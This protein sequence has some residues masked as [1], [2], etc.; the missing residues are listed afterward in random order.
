MTFSVETFIN[1]KDLINPNSV[2]ELLHINY[3]QLLIDTA[4][5]L[6]NKNTELFLSSKKNVNAYIL[7]LV[8]AYTTLTAD[9]M[10]L[11]NNLINIKEQLNTF[12]INNVALKE[13]LEHMYE[14]SEGS[15]ELINDY[16]QLYNINYTKN[17]GIL[18]SIIFSCYVMSTIFKS[19]PITL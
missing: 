4:N 13:E 11:S 19:K 9:S 14:M 7:N 16:K 1:P 18:L 10:R 15:S 17:W 6:I 5:A 2:K 12:K 8:N 3:N